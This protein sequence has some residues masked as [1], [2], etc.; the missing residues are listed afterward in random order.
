[1]EATGRGCEIHPDCLRILPRASGCGEDRCFVP[2]HDTVLQAS[3]HA[4]I[5]PAFIWS[6]TA[7]EL[8]CGARRYK[9]RGCL[10]YHDHRVSL[11]EHIDRGWREGFSCKAFY[12]QLKSTSERELMT[13]GGS[14]DGNGSPWSPISQPS[15]PSLTST[16]ATPQGTRR[17]FSRHTKTDMIHEWLLKAEAAYLS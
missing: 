12:W 5:D 14:Q 17:F 2:Q 8:V 16:A 6:V 13:G 11:L 4:D 10:R 1:M 15:S 7:V 3:L 9:C